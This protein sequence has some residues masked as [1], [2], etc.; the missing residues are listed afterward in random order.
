MFRTWEF[1]KGASIFVSLAL[2]PVLLWLLFDVVLILVGGVL[3]AVLLALGASPFQRM[4]VPR[5][6]AF[7]L[8][9]VLIACIVAGAAY[10]FG[11][12]TISELQEVL[13]R[14][15]QAQAN[16]T[17]ALNESQIGKAILSHVHDANVPVADL[18]SRVFSVS[19]NFIIGIVVMIF[20]GI[21]LAAQPALYREGMSKL[22]PPEWRISAVETADSLAD[23]LRLWLLGQLMDMMIIGVLSGL[24]VWLIGLPSPAALGVIA[25][26]GDFIPYLGPIL[27]AI[28][29][30]LV[31]VT[32]DFSAVLWTLLAYLLI[33]QIEGQLVMPLIQQRMVYIPPAVMLGSIVALSALF[34][35]VATIFAAPITVILFVLVKKLY[36]R[37]SLGEP[38]QLP[39]ETA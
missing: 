2:V 22:F 18:L 15:E 39:G 34:G 25:G 31:A 9:G 30:L 19:A 6:L 3:I 24:A 8:S 28:P 12:S 16:I 37:D 13:R 5:A 23:A 11:A 32:L 20:I 14:I 38:V 1:A 36:V 35:V 26:V 17:S 21:Y 10:L 29:A 4:K 27:A 33:H 7:V